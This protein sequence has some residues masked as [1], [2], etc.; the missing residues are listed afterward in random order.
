MIF[1]KRLLCSRTALGLL[2]EGSLTSFWSL[3]GST[4]PLLGHSWPS[5][6]DSWGPSWPS[7]APLGVNLEPLGRLL[8]ST[9]SLFDA[10]WVQLGLNL[11]LGVS[12]LAFLGAP[13]APKASQ[14][15]SR[16]TKNVVSPKILGSFILAEP[17][18][19]GKVPLPCSGNQNM[20]NFLQC[21]LRAMFIKAIMGLKNKAKLPAVPTK[22]HVHQS[23]HRRWISTGAL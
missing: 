22:G 20:Q 19:S 23:D 11:A 18:L 14:D 5:L 10:S 16:A 17:S 3:L 9:W 6:G 7:Q 8:A 13:S 12:I 1:Q 2:F 4:W 15:R 21:Q